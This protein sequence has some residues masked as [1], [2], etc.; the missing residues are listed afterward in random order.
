MPL[1]PSEYIQIWFYITIWFIIEII[2][3]ELFA[4]SALQ[5]AV[6]QMQRDMADATAA[7]TELVAK[8]KAKSS[9]LQTVEAALDEK[10]SAM[11]AINLASSMEISDLKRYVN[12]YIYSSLLEDTQ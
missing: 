8:C 5:S 11:S 1:R 4:R 3:T 7:R 2:T 6:K 10:S 12:I 9:E